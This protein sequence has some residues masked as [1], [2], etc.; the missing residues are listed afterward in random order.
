MKKY[1]ISLGII[2]LTIS[3][4]VAQTT[5]TAGAFDARSF[6]ATIMSG[7]IL[8]TCTQVYMRL[9]K[10]WR[11]QERQ[12]RI[13]EIKIDSMTYALSVNLHIGPDFKVAFEKKY[14]E[15]IKADTF[16]EN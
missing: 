14:E 12:N 10:H 15:L 3:G 13:Q 5:N 9:K 6:F 8:F 7:L 4:C 1:F 11:I 16:I 2:L